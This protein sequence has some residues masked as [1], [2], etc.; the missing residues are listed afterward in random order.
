[1]IDEKVCE[2]NLCFMIM[3]FLDSQNVR[4]IQTEVQALQKH[5]MWIDHSVGYIQID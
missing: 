5:V 2:I 4:A 3:D 1:M